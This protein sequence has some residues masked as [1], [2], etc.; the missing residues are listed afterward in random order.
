MYLCELAH[1]KRQKE[2]PR[3]EPESPGM[4]TTSIR[5]SGS[6]ATILYSLYVLPTCAACMRPYYSSSYDHPNSAEQRIQIAKRF[7]YGV[8]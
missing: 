1:H 5:L 4:S 3:L 8:F 2:W 6:A 7:N